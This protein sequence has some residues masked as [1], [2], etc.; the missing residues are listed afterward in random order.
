VDVFAEMIVVR[1]PELF[2]FSETFQQVYYD[3]SIYEVLLCMLQHK[4]NLFLLSNH[5]TLC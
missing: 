3:I 4:W 2:S 1:V 5:T